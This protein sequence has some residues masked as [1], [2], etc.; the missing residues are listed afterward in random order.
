MPRMNSPQSSRP[1]GSSGGTF[2]RIPTRKTLAAGCAAAGAASATRA[3]TM[4]IRILG[5]RAVSPE[6]AETLRLNAERRIELRAEVLQR[7]RRGQL[8]DLRLAEVPPQPGVQ[9]VGDLLSRDR[10]LLRVLERV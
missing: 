5:I 3:T 2:D 6:H 9:L 8:D 1:C 4:P 7:H 10:H